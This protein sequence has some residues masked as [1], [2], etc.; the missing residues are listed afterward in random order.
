MNAI[1]KIEY[2]KAPSIKVDYYIAMMRTKITTHAD[3]KVNHDRKIKGWYKVKVTDILS[4]E[5]PNVTAAQEVLEACKTIISEVASI[6][7]FDISITE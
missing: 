3:L 6:S 5:S 7:Q 2:N 1:L 4:I